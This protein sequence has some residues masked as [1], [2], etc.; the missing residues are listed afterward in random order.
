MGNGAFRITSPGLV[1]FYWSGGSPKPHQVLDIS[2]T[3]FYLLT[4][5]LWSPQTM[6]R[7]TL[8]RP[9]TEEGNPKHSIT[10]LARVVRIGPD[11][12]GHEFVMTESLKRKSF[13]LLPDKGTDPK[14]LKR[15]LQ[16]LQ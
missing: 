7:V 6:L 15:F 13:D 11:G 5:E 14:A 2:D 12:V 3:G 4:Q 16:P 10:V 9:D 1:A 8:Q